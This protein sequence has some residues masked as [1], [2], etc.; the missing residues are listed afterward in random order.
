MVHRSKVKKTMELVQIY[1]KNVNKLTI[2]TSTVSTNFLAFFCYY[3]K[4]FPHG[5]G[6]RREN[7]YGSMRIWIHSLAF[8]VFKKEPS[9]KNLVYRKVIQISLKWCRFATRPVPVCKKDK[10]EIFFLA[11]TCDIG[12]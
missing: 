11:E 7:E 12:H 9:T 2:I 4:I 3:F 1:F 10:K 6:S 5:S 8:T